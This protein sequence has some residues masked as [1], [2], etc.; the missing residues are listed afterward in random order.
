MALGAAL[1][2]TAAIAMADPAP[3][4]I[5]IQADRLVTYSNTHSAEFIGHVKVT[6][7]KT[8]ITANRLRIIYKGGEAAQE[9]MNA[10][11][12]DS[13]K[14]TGNVRIEMDGR[15]AES[16]QAVYTTADKKL[17][18]SGPG[19]QVNLGQ[20]QIV[21]GSVITFY[22]ESGRVEIVG[23]KKNPVKATIRSNQ[24]GLN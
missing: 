1:L 11:S 15:T 10:E 22:R 14:A 13:I 8:T 21:K 9:G 18:L 4:P 3:Q 16:Q 6:Q 19:T 2:S 12:I 5:H 23:D 24:R 7:D 20:E 17:V